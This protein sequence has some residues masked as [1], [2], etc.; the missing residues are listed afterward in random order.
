MFIFAVEDSYPPAAVKKA[1]VKAVVKDAGMK[2]AGM[3]DA[4]MKDAG[5]KDA[6]VGVVKK[7][8]SEVS[9]GLLFFI[10]I[11]RVY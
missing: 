4:G 8:K 10:N 9:Q 6:V 3:K 5:M 1:V 2:D 11:R 7:Q